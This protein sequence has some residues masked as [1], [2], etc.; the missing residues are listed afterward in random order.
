MDVMDGLLPTLVLDLPLLRAN[1][2]KSPLSLSLLSSSS[3]ELLLLVLLLL[4]E[5][6]VT[7]TLTACLIGISGEEGASTFCLGLAGTISMN[8]W[9]GSVSEE[10]E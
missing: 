8:F 4:D 5:E 10:D 7:A 2:P 3:S 1:W 6:D 9:S